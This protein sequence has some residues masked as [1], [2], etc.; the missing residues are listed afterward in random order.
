MLLKERCLGQAEVPKIQAFNPY[1]QG[2]SFQG[3]EIPIFSLIWSVSDKTLILADGTQYDWQY[4]YSSNRG[5]FYGD[6][7]T[8]SHSSMV[9]LGMSNPPIIPSVS[10]PKKHINAT[11]LVNPDGTKE[12]SYFNRKYGEDNGNLLYSAVFEA[13]NAIKQKKRYTYNNGSVQGFTKNWTAQYNNVGGQRHPYLIN[14]NSG[15]YANQKKF[16]TAYGD[17]KNQLAKLTQTTVYGDTGGVS[18]Y[19][20]N[21]H[22]YNA[23]EAPTHIQQYSNTASRHIKLGYDADTTRWILNQPTYTRVGATSAQASS[24]NM[25]QT[26][27]YSKTHSLY[28]FMPYQE[29]WFAQTRKT[30]VSYHTYSGKKGMPK[31][32]EMN[33]PLATNTSAK[34]R[35][36]FVNYKRGQATQVRVKKRYDNGTMSMYKVVDNNQL[37]RP[38]IIKSNKKYIFLT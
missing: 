16:R 30:F 19:T 15:P 17:D 1:G 10:T 20:N 11:Y 2:A 22:T 6:T 37:N 4:G 35:V 3:Y 38:P 8:S 26:V 29:K 28:P 34:R 31:V 32:V 14:M 27:Y 33:A 18:T 7:T 24:N 25:S 9:A 13:N 21:V 23:Y 36:E 5:Y 12:V